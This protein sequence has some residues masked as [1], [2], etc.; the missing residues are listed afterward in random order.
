MKIQGLYVQTKQRHI[1]RA[2]LICV[3]L[4]LAVALFAWQQWF[5]TLPRPTIAILPI[6]AT[7]ARLETRDLADHL[8]RRFRMMLASRAEL[9]VIE[10]D[11]STHPSLEG[12]PVTAQSG[13]LAAEYVL[14]GSVSGREQNLRLSLQLFTA[15]GD[16]IWSERFESPLLHQ[17][18]LQEWVLEALW[19]QLPL[20]EEALAETRG[21]LASC[22]YPADTIAILTLARVDRRGGDSA[23][24]AMVA[25]EH[26]DAGLLHLSKA[27]F[28]FGQ[29]KALPPTQRP[30]IQNLAMQSLGLVERTCPEYPEIELLR[31]AHTREL[32]RENASGYLARHPNAVALYLALAELHHEA[33]KLRTVKALVNEALLLDPLGASTR[34]RIRE[35][36]ESTGNNDSACP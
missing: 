9:R 14:S 18:Q 12:L 35:L 32:Q 27:R 8:T 30:V 10:L 25:A 13:S 34:C 19:P 15:D 11:S 2:A 26:D 5:V 17:Q 1:I 36:Q 20:Q 23:T 4:V 24:L 6:E 21:L 33:G 22:A 7:D 16:L 28:Y 29:I 3:A 31:L